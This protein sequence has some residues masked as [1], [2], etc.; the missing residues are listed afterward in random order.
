MGVA[1]PVFDG[2]GRLKAAIH[3]S[4]LVSTILEDRLKSIVSEL[5]QTAQLISKDLS[6][7]FDAESPTSARPAV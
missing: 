1:V 4:A 5:K 3:V 2:P 6:G 7:G